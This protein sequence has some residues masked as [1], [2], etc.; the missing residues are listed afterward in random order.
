VGRALTLVDEIWTGYT[1]P[2]MVDTYLNYFNRLYSLA[3][4]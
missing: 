2:S 3:K 4:P 1:N